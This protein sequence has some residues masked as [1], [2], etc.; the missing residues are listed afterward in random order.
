MKDHRIIQK[1]LLLLY[2]AVVAWLCFG[3]FEALPQV[4][5][6]LFGIPTDKVV[7]FVMFFP[8]P[9][10]LYLAFN[11]KTGSIFKSLLLV[12]GLV[13]IGIL[14]SIGT[15]LIQG[16]TT[17]RSKDLLDFAADTVSVCCSALIVLLIELYKYFK[18]SHDNAK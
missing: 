8:L 9:I 15:E 4:S 12:A 5:R 6:T 2:L 3:R 10:L 17:Y 18:P 13:C 7:H 16:I 1:L 14:T 11:W